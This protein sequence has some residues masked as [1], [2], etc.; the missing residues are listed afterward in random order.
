MLHT[1]TYLEKYIYTKCET[2]FV[3]FAVKL[4]SRSNILLI[5]F[6][7]QKIYRE[8]TFIDKKSRNSNTHIGA[9]TISENQQ[10]ANKI[11]A[12]ILVKI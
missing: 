7:R 2:S 10:L 3:T 5:Y 8:Y 6:Y 11:Q 4:Y 12:N 9:N 1:K